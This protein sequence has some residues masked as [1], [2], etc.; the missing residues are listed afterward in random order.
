MRASKVAAENRNTGYLPP[1]EHKDQ[2]IL[3]D[4]RRANLMKEFDEIDINKDG[5]LQRKE[6]KDFI[7][8]KAKE[9]DYDI[10]NFF[11]SI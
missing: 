6:I 9:K 1:H 2:K 7:Y 11:D 10:G 4:R 5:L 8:R 3:S